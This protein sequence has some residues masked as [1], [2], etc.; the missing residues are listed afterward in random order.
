M[1]VSHTG[2]ACCKYC[3]AEY[4]LFTIYNKDMQGFCK[5]WRNR[6]ERACKDKTP[7]QRRKWAAKYQGAGVVDS[8]IVVDLGHKG[9]E[10]CE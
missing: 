5:A 8:P 9:F 6:H 10:E 2:F 7:A 3:G 1:G 4:R